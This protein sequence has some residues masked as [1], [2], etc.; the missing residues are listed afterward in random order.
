MLCTLDGP[1]S[2]T[3]GAL[4]VWRAGSE[5]VACGSEADAGCAAKAGQ[6]E[7]PRHMVRETFLAGQFC[8]LL[9]RP[10]ENTLR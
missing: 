7:M 9:V 10:A 5:A 2:I 1:A 3:A 8:S 4:Q 6:S